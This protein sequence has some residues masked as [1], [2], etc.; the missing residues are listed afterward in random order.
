MKGIIRIKFCQSPTPRAIDRGSKHILLNRSTGN[1]AGL[2]YQMVKF[3]LHYRN[4]FHICW[5]FQNVSKCLLEVLRYVGKTHHLQNMMFKHCGSNRK[6]RCHGR[7]YRA[8]TIIIYGSRSTEQ[9]CD[10]RAP[11]NL[12][13]FCQSPS[14]S[15]NWNLTRAISRYSGSD[16]D[17]LL[18]RGCTCPVQT[19]L[20]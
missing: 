8:R 18:L 20:R 2:T 13:M 11:N 16:P 12:M 7:F 14:D 4:R 6:H 1:C 10:D 9:D 15:R 19:C 3:G 17:G 5:C